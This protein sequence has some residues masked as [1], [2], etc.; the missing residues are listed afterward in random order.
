MRTAVKE[1]S[2][3]CYYSHQAQYDAQSAIIVDYIAKHPHPAP[4]RREIA[5]A[6]GIETSSVSARVNKLLTDK[7][8]HELP[9]RKCSISGIKAHTLMITPA[10]PEQT[11]LFN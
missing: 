10:K 5:K 4:T 8:L 7:V 11:Q 3:D 6:T 2:I 9:R 1:T